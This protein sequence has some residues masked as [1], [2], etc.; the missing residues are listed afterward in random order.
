MTKKVIITVGIYG[1]GKSYQAE[2]WVKKH[3]EYTIC[4]CYDVPIEEL[5]EGLKDYEYIIMDYYFAKDPF[6]RKLYELLKCEIEFWILFDKPEVIVQRQLTKRQM[7]DS[8]KDP[9]IVYE[10]YQEQLNQEGNSF[11]DLPETRFFDGNMKEYTKE[12]FLV[13]FNEWYKPPTK[14]EVTKFLAEMDAKPGYDKYYHHF[15]LPHGIRIGKEGY[16]R[17]EETWAI[18][19][20]WI[21]W[22]DKYVLDLCCFHAYFCQEIFK[23]GGKPTGM[24]KST[25][26]LFTAGVFSKW[27]YT[28]FNLYHYDIDDVDHFVTPDNFIK[29][30]PTRVD[31]KNYDLIMLFNVLHHLKNQETLLRSIARYPLALFE[32]NNTQR[33]LIER[34]FNIIRETQS[35]KDNRIILLCKPKAMYKIP[36]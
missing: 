26:A 5:A 18:I 10:V 24:D 27:A 7:W 8:P 16:A 33:G 28:S 29:F 21:D 15:N 30:P 19:K 4:P 22:K 12:E 1:V 9:W 14:E 23:V 36:A 3:P 20:D 31:G 11:Y 2:Q 13:Q 6:A 32:I 35:P 25:A 34:F 17:N